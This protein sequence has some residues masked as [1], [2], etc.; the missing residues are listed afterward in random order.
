MSL[1]RKFLKDLGIE[2]DEVDKIIRE[3]LSTVDSL[4]DDIDSLKAEAEKSKAVEKELN[5]LKESVKAS[6]SYKEK[7]EKIE[8]EFNDYK[9]EVQNEKSS[10]Q[11]SEAY[12]NL[13]KSAGIGDKRIESVLKLAKVEGLLDKLE[14]D[15]DGAV[16]NSKAVEDEIKSVYADYIEEIKEKG[17]NTPNPPSNTGNTFESMTL[18]EKMAYANSNPDSAEVQKFLRG[19]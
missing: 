17:P 12:K 16:K 5:D 10:N 15:T 7:Y 9:A 6:D 13:L 19:E 11:K 8:K 3:H 2:G 1:T 4:K 14:F 18:A